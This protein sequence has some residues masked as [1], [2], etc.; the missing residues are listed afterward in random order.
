MERRPQGR[1]EDW[2]FG[3]HIAVTVASTMEKLAQWAVQV[4]EAVVQC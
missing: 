4:R 1:Q 2:A 3:E